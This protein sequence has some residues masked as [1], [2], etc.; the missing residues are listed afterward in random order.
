MK[1]A[2]VVDGG[3]EMG[4]GH[5]YRTVNLARDLHGRAASCFVTKSDDI[6]V[7]LIEG[8]GF[9]VFHA[10]SDD[11][12]VEIL[13]SI[14]PGIVIIDRLDIGEKMARDIKD[15]VKA[16]LVLFEN[17]F[18]PSNKYAD[19]VVNAIMGAGFNNKK[20]RDEQTGTLYFFGPKYLTFKD[21]FYQFK[22][23]GKKLKRVI[24]KM[25]L[26]F[27]GSDPSNLTSA[28]L[29]ELLSHDTDFKIGIVLG[30]HFEYFKELNRILEKYPQK[31]KNVKIYKAANNVAELMYKADLVMASPGLS[32]FES[33]CVGT[34]V[35][36][37]HQNLWQRDGFKGFVDTLDKKEINRI[38]RM[39][40]QGAYVDPQ[41][42][43]IKNLEI[44]QGKAELIEAIIGG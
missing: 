16:R 35:I 20:Y 44:G 10:A 43:S 26:I 23:K 14:E 33:L 25:L 22:K 18:Q 27:G 17:Q 30:V 6:V 39:I 1:I 41:Q 7:K 3:L 34:P 11:E 24:Q 40:K 31:K 4:M 12:I 32:V 5:V 13:K 19:V 28:A 2:F 37:V 36:V 21:D 29:S 15:G 42:N 9:S 8:A 38:E